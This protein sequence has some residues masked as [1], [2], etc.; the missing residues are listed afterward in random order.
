M[1]SVDRVTDVKLQYQNADA[2]MVIGIFVDAP[3]NVTDVSPEQVLNASSPIVVTLDG[4]VIDVRAEQP[5][6]AD[7]PILVT[8]TGIVIDVTA[9]Q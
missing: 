1:L 5:E 3:E 2:P 7:S 8:P 9:E 4:I 6:N